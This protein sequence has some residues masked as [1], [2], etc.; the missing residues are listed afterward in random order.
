MRDAE[1]PE[2][3]GLILNAFG[4]AGLRNAYLNEADKMPERAKEVTPQEG[5]TAIEHA[6]FAD[7]IVA[8]ANSCPGR[9]RRPGEFDKLEI[10]V[11]EERQ[12]GSGAGRGIRVS[13]V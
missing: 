7:D 3:L 5:K 6:G 11:N 8:L 10:E 12:G 1:A 9:D 13:W 2:R 4:D